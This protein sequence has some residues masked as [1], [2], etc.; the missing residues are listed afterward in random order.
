MKEKILNFLNEG[1]PLLWIKGQNFHEIEN[2]IVEGLNAFENKRYYIYEKGTTINRQNNSVEVGMGNLFTTLDELYPQG[3]RKVPV[4]LLIKDS[5]AEIVDENNLEYIKEIVETKTANP[6]YNFTLIVVDQQNTVPEDLRE[7]ASLVDDEQKRTDEMAL[8]KAILDITKIEK[9][10]LDLAKLEKIELDL[11]SIEKI[12]QSLKDDIKKI[13]VGEKPAELKPTFEDMVFV[14]GGKYQ[15]SFTD[16]EKE[17]SN[18]EVSKY[19]ITQ[20]LWQELIRNNPANFKGDEN[21]PIEYISWWHALE[22]CNRL[23][24]K[25]GLRPVYN[26]GKSDQGLLMINQLDGT[27]ASP[28][29]AD[30]NKTEGF[31]LPTEVEWEWFARGGQVALDNGTFDYTYSGSN[32]ID[33]VAWY[34]GNSK[35]TTQSVGLKMPNVLGLYDCNGN[36]WEWCYDTTEGIESG[37]SY[38][39]KA[40]DHSNVYRRL[41]GGSWCNNTEV[42]AVAVRGN[43][44]ATYAYSNAGFRIVRTVL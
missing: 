33:D 26:L 31:R 39:Y 7:I 29:V 2:I 8:K 17:V 38:V 3:I 34:T 23:S 14:K 21:R 13:T 37:K 36:V 10:E 19:L 43:S 35:D 24:E 41:K 9:I 42:C 28:D 1:K 5:L 40:Y 22:F 44:Q 4:F 27:V 16:E 25:Y 32:N 6:K 15:P 20:K 12:V 30:F 18:L 11:D